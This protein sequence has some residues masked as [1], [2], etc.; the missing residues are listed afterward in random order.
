MV[1]R[2]DK[3]GHKIQVWEVVH[4]RNEALDCDVLCYAA[5]K[6]LQPVFPELAGKIDNV[7]KK[8]AGEPVRETKK[9]QRRKRRVISKG[10]GGR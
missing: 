10:I 6:N 2:F 3:T 4:K 8:Q 5:A 1:E 9:Q 7:K